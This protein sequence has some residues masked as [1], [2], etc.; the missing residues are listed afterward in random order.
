M[1]QHQTGEVTLLLR[2]IAAGQA[3]AKGLLVAEGTPPH[4]VCLKAAGG[5][6]S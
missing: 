3:E 1:T 4:S 6:S 5:F 2:R